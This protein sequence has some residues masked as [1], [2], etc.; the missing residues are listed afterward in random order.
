MRPVARRGPSTC[1]DLSAAGGPAPGRPSGTGPGRPRG[2]M[3]RAGVR[4]RAAETGIVATL[5]P[6]LPEGVRPSVVTSTSADPTGAPTF[7]TPASCWPTPTPIL[8]FDEHEVVLPI[9]VVTELEAKRH[10]PELGL[11]RPAGPA[12]ARRLPAPVTAASTPRCR[13]ATW[14]APFVS[15]ST[16]PTPACCPPATGWGTT[17]LGSSRSPATCRPRVRRHGRL[18]GPAAADQGLVRGTARRG[19]PRGAGHHGLRLDRDVRAGGRWPPTG[20]PALRG[21]E[22]RDIAEARELP[23]HTG[24]VLQSSAARPRPGHRRRHVRLV[25]GDREAFGL[26]GRSRRAAHRARPSAR[27]RRRHRLP[28]RP[29]RYRQ[30][31]ARARARAW[32]RSSNA[33]STRR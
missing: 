33:G 11:L 6:D 28:G 21:Q 18:Q 10:H 13:S 26:R 14:A 16:T 27:R 3:R 23:C 9:V 25:R 31:R 24:L 8:R 32:R 4:A 12:P 7:S 20:R 19:V 1:C 30:V 22:S 2:Q 5:A 15:S 17:T 29:G